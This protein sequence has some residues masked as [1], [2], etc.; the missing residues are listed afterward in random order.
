MVRRLAD[1]PELTKTLCLTPSHCDHSAS[2]A[3]TFLFCVRIG[4]SCFRNSMSVSRS[5]R[6][7]LLSMSGQFIAILVR[8]VRWIR[9]HIS[10]EFMRCRELR[11]LGFDYAR[12]Y[13]AKQTCINLIQAFLRNASFQTNRT[14]LRNGIPSVMIRRLAPIS[15]VEIF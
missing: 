1:A 13:S 3:F 8:P 2:N 11:F 7:M 12:F 4:L 15:L 10:E 6:V 9:E 14:H 5:W